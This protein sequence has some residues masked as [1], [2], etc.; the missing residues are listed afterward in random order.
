MA[1]AFTLLTHFSQ[2]Y[3]KM[4]PLE[5][6]LGRQGVGVA[7]DN[8]EVTPSRLR[9]IPALYPALQRWMWEHLEARRKARSLFVRRVGS[10]MIGM[11][12]GR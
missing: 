11:R 2:R 8:M 7:F 4:P 5:E 6:V 9:S 1:A 3:A 12:L 10:A